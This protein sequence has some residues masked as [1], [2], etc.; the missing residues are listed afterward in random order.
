MKPNARLCSM[1]RAQA[2]TKVVPLGARSAAVSR[3]S[4]FCIQR[5][6]KLLHLG[7]AYSTALQMME[8]A[9]P[10]PEHAKASQAMHIKH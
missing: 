6:H 8:A 1:A 2:R 5:D 7:A 10:S 9:F 4:G 3:I